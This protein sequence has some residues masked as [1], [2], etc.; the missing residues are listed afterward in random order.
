[1]SLHPAWGTG[2]EVSNGRARAGALLPDPVG[3]GRRSYPQ[4][5]ADPAGSAV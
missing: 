2:G 1:M 5:T 3:R 4:H